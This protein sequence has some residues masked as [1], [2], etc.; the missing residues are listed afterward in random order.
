MNSNI[1]SGKYSAD[2]RIKFLFEVL[3]SLKTRNYDYSKGI[4]YNDSKINKYARFK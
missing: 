1:P 2:T 4:F 3:S